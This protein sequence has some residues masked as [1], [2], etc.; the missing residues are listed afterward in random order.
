MESVLSKGQQARSPE[1]M[2]QSQSRGM[3]KMTSQLNVCQV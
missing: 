3:K 1:L 2:F